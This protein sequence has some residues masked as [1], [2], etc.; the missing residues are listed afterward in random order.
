MAVVLPF[1]P[2]AESAAEPGRRALGELLV[3]AGAIAPARLAEALDA[4]REQDE[5][6]GRILLAGGAI[7]RD[8]LWLALSRQSGLG[9][10]DLV[11]SPPDPLLL[12]GQDPYRCIAL[13]AM[14]WR[15]VGGTRVVALS[16]PASA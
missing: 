11:A 5:R 14:P 1:Q 9:V 3:E 15:Q 13:E 16:N 4:Q 12:R 7:S 8:D 10:V 6:L 2:A